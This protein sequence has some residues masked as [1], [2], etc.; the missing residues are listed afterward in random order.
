MREEGKTIWKKFPFA[1]GALRNLI[2][3][4]TGAGFQIKTSKREK[5]LSSN[6]R[7][8][9]GTCHPQ[10]QSRKESQLLSHPMLLKITNKFKEHKELIFMALFRHSLSKKTKKGRKLKDEKRKTFPKKHESSA[11][12]L[13]ALKCV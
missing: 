8:A 11:K 5:L 7:T 3:M 9:S 12:L 4:W 6:K 2:T 1:L 10:K 13:F